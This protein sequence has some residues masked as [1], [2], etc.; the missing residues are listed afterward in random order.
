MNVQANL[1]RI[2]EHLY[3]LE[4]QQI[5]IRR[6]LNF[7]YDWRT[8]LRDLGSE[9]I[10]VVESH[11]DKIEH[12]YECVQ[13]RKA[14]LQATQENFSDLGKLSNELLVDTMKTLEQHGIESRK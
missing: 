14:Y 8:Q 10:L 11:I 4:R 3:I 1:N 9:A 7:L 5:E 13:R 6:M 12:V 2:T